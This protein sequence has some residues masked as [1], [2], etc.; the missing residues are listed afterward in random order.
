MSPPCRSRTPIFD[1]VLSTL[2]MHHWTEPATGLAEIARV[3]RPD[4]H[5]IVWDFRAGRVPLH[6]HLPDPVDR[7]AGSPLRV[8]SNTTWRWPGRIQLLRRIVFVPAV[9]A[10]V[11]Y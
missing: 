2:A 5:V 10:Q 1:L 11:A 6:G 3:L 9:P 8:A 4:G 7:T